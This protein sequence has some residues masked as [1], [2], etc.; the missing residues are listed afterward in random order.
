MLKIGNFK[1][2]Q[3]ALEEYISLG[4]YSQ[5][6]VIA[7]WNSIGKT[8]LLK[9]VAKGL[10]E[11]LGFC[12]FSLE[13]NDYYSQLDEIIGFATKK[14]EKPTVA[15]ININL[16]GRLRSLLDSG[17]KIHLMKFEV[18][19]WLEWATAG[20]NNSFLPNIESKMTDFIKS[21]P[22]KAHPNIVQER[23]LHVYLN[24]GI[25]E[26]IDILKQDSLEIENISDIRHALNN[27]YTSYHSA[28]I[29]KESI[30]KDWEKIGETFSSIQSKLDPTL[31]TEIASLLDF[32]NKKIEGDFF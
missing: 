21:N 30:L 18:N 1:K 25:D 12:S 17:I 16:E 8:A 5:S 3:K 4:D 10:E 23:G 2:T 27:I 15:L 6:F 28:F 7:G 31:K 22:E 32:Y 19:E 11:D 9:E 26:L 20:Q 24:N 13:N 14:R 29:L